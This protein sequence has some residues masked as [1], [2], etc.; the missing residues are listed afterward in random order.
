LQL[1][2]APRMTPRTKHYGIKYHF[3]R[4]YVEK[5]DIKLHKVDTKEQR[6]DIFTKGLVQAIFEYLREL[7]MGW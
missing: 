5:G 4:D 2:R 3:F 6:A 1:A 7:L